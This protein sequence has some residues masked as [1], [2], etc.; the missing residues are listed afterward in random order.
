MPAFRFN[1]K[2]LSQIP[3]LQ[4]LISLGFRYL[5]PEQAYRARG[6]KYGNVLLEE[7]LREQLKKINRIRYKGGEHHFAQFQPR[8]PQRRFVGGESHLYLGRKYRLKIRRSETEGVLLTHGFFHI[9][10]ADTGPQRVASL[11]TAWYRRRSEICFAQ[12]FE[13]CWRRHR[14][15][16]RGAEKPILKIR[17]MKTRW[18]SLSKKGAMTLNLELIKTPRECIEYVIVHELCHLLHLNHG[19][20]FYGLLESI[21]PDWKRRKQKLEKVCA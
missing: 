12:I 9:T 5:T 3:A 21:L 8:T 20:A 13:D 7:I 16:K 14:F 15:Q 18:G 17:T 19:K 2:Y 1:E 10:V 4:Q 6:K 11:L